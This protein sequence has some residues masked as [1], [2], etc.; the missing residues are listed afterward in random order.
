[1]QLLSLSRDLLVIVLDD[2]DANASELLLGG[3]SDVGEELLLQTGSGR[4][5]LDGDDRRRTQENEHTPG[6]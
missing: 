6:T 5:G 3:S 4:K 1:M 2:L